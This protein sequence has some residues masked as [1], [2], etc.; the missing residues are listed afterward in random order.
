M[1][2]R[3]YGLLG[4]KLGH[5]YSVPIHKKLGNDKY[6][7]YELPDETICYCGHGPETTIGDEKHFGC[8]I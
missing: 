6:K 2:E 5:S 4:R 3:I 8:V 7:L 1:E